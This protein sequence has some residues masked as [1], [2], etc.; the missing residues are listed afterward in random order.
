MPNET[1]RL[2]ELVRTALDEFES[3]SLSASVRRALRI[4]QL[5]GDAAM[6]WFCR[7]DLRPMGGSKAMQRGELQAIWPEADYA[8]WVTTHNALLEE[9]MLERTPNDPIPGAPTGEDSILGGSVSELEAQLALREGTWREEFAD[10]VVHKSELDRRAYADRS[11]LERIR[12]RMYFYLCRCETELAVGGIAA[13]VFD[14]HR[15]RVDETLSAVAPEILEQF[16]AAHRRAID[17]DTESLAHA[18]TSCRRI[19]K[20]VADVVFPPRSDPF[21]GKDGKERIVD[22][23]RYKNRLLAFIQDAPHQTAMGVLSASFEDLD[24]RIGALNEL[25]SKGVHANVQQSEVDLCVV[26]TYMLA[27][28]ILAIHA[29]Q[30]AI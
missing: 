16:T 1:E 13:N 6:A 10:D 14:R 17:G 3:A 2:I 30:Q 15:R 23:E 18:L 8:T 27:G 29:Q 4:A 26:Q 24:N 11:V 19:L 7:L 28:E 5:R 20:A 25:D 9:W 12:Q 22:D 21:T